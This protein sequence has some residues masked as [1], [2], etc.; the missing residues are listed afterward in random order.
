MKKKSMLW[1]VLSMV[2]VLSMMLAAC[3]PAAAPVE[4]APVAEEPAAEPAVA[5]EPVAEEAPVVE[6]ATEVEPAVVAYW[7]TMSD[8]ETAQLDLVIADFEAANPGITIEAT[9]Y[10]WDDFK[11]AAA[12]GIGRRRCPRHGPDGYRLGL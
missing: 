3:T 8:P 10:S 2:V 12:D 11:P 1:L 7:H 9:R 4:E 6:E 5:E